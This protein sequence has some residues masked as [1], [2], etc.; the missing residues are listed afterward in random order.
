MKKAIF[1]T[2]MLFSALLV[3]AQ[4]P[5]KFNYQAVCR[6][7]SG[8]VIANQAVTFRLTIHDITSAGTILYRETQAATT[9]TFGLVNLQIGNGTAVT[10]YNDFTSIPWNTGEKYLE[11]ELDPGTGYVSLGSPQLLSVPYALLQKPDK[12]TTSGRSK[13][14]TSELL[15]FSKRFPM[16]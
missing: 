8:A 14:T 13:L 11:V 10:P 9:N 1:V 15:F 2:V 6:N 4:A 16:L 12:L 5:Q 3:F 7:N